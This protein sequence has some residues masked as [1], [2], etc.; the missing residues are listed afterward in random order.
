MAVAVHVRGD[1][2][3]AVA[4]VPHAGRL[5]HVLEAEVPQV[6]VQTIASRGVHD[7]DIQPA[8]PVRVQ[9][10]R[11]GSHDL[12]VLLLSGGA[13]SSGRSR[14]RSVRSR[15]R[16]PARPRPAP[17]PAASPAPTRNASRLP[18]ERVDGFPD[19]RRRVRSVRGQQRLRQSLR[20]RDVQWRRV[21]AGTRLAHRL[22][23]AQRLV[24][25][26]LASWRLPPPNPARAAPRPAWPR[27]PRSA[28]PA[29]RPSAGRP[30]RPTAGPS[31]AGPS[32]APATTPVA[33]RPE[34]R[35]TAAPRL[36]TDG[37]SPPPGDP[38]PP[39][40]RRPAATPRP[41]AGAELRPRPRGRAAEEEPPAPT[42]VPP[43]AIRSTM[44]RPRRSPSDRR[45][46]PA[47][48][49]GAP[50]QPRGLRGA[51]SSA[52]SAAARASSGR[53]SASAASACSRCAGGT[54]SWSVASVR[55]S[56][57]ASA[58]RP[59]SRSARASC[60]P[61][62]TAA[63]E[64]HETPSD[65]RGPVR[66]R[67]CSASRRAAS[68]SP[69]RSSRGSTRARLNQADASKGSRRTASPKSAA[70]P[71]KSRSRIRIT[72]RSYQGPGHAGRRPV[73]RSTSGLASSRRPAR[74]RVRARP[75]VARGSSR[76]SSSAAR[77]ASSA[78]A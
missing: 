25:L 76:S 41:R 33:D 48:P 63:E 39:R 18:P 19:L 53:S 14:S 66:E 5:R 37:P 62:P 59:A 27:P 20:R 65:C 29:R 2:A 72:P 57:S 55:D 75:N 73:A 12:A 42:R 69:E 47:R 7:V 22:P 4:L 38:A 28:A 50:R 60:R 13:R 36:P 68:A 31:P 15:P 61:L 21:R 46:A 58:I 67:A 78:P 40:P 49:A 24:P 70:A 74:T 1:G 16:R 34:P 32:R 54:P 30:W 17:P 52:R 45:P 6:P 26:L 35:P 8:V 3:H 51:R 71:S 64:C 11:A 10:R 77:N 43:R 56:R 9:Q 44:R 23:P